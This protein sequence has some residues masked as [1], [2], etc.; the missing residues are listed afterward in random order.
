[1][2]SVLHVPAFQDNYIWLIRAGQRVAIV[3]PGDAAPV[4]AAL[5]REQLTPTAV[6][7]THHHRDHVGGAGELARRYGVPVFG[8]GRA[9][10]PA[11]TRILDEGD[12]LTL[13]ELD[14]EFDVF[15]TPGHTLDHIAFY[16]DAGGHR[17][18]FC[19][20]TLFS[21]GCGRL[22]EGSAAQ[23]HDSLARL[24]GLPDDTRLYCGHEYTAQNLRFAQTV[25]PDNPD[26]QA[27][28]ARVQDLRNQDRPSLPS[29]IGLERRIN[30]FLRAGVA[31][32]R[33]AAEAFAQEALATDTEVFAAV[34]RWKDG[35]RG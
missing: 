16:S 2:I 9:H 21:A 20:D 1:M 8:P 18:L 11:V 22:F 32:V 19:G 24:A 26:V 31:S 15:A 34:R 23:L 25:E 33:R 10:I 27:H 17:L 7:C 4:M 35:F 14:V 3:D 13:P 5:E 28:L 6:L 29:T 30:P 12:R